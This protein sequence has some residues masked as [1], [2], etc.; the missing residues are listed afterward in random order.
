[1]WLSLLIPHGSSRNILLTVKLIHQDWKNGL[2]ILILITIIIIT[3][4]CLYVEAICIKIDY[5]VYSITICS[6]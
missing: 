5:Y 3:V 2:L 6:Y 4:I 1:M